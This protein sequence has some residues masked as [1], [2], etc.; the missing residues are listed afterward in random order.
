MILFCLGL[1][2]GASI[3]ALVARWA[4]HGESRCP[5][6]GRDTAELRLVCQRCYDVVD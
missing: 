6:C 4:M 1:V 3:A 5:R 2:C